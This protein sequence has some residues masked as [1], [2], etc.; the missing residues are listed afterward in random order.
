MFLGKK[1]IAIVDD[2]EALLEGTSGFLEAMG[3]DVLAFGSG[4]A[5]LESPHKDRVDVLLTDINMPG[6]SGLDLQNV[7]RV[8]RPGIPVV[9]MTALRD[10]MLRQ[11]AITGGARELL[12]KPILAD[13]LIRCLEDV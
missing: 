9:M 3:Y 12:Q 10:D 1:T 7:V 5:F 11:R 2:D 13:D 6:M 8:Q 4:E